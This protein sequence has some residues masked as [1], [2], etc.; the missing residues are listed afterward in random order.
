MISFQ[1]NYKAAE[2]FFK[3]FLPQVKMKL[4]IIVFSKYILNGTPINEI[5]N[6]ELTTALLEA[7]TKNLYEKFGHPKLILS[8]TE[9]ELNFPLE[10][11]NQRKAE[12]KNAFEFGL[13]KA[14]KILVYGLLQVV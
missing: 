9:G 5:E 8:I 7:T 1:G 6:A 11:I 3:I 13:Q 4:I 14:A 12:I 2:V 10:E